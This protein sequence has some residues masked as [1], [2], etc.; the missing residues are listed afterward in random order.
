MTFTYKLDYNKRM[1]TS[2]P[3]DPLEAEIHDLRLALDMTRW[4]AT[5]MEERQALRE[6]Q[7]R[8]FLKTVDDH[9]YFKQR[10]YASV[11]RIKDVRREGGLLLA[12]IKELELLRGLF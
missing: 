2:R 1:K 3:T 9:Y 8:P 7:R 11:K 10:R 12:R 5:N 4:S 6:K